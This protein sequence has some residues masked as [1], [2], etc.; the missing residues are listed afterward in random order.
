MGN[1]D[2]K[3][4][5]K[6]RAGQAQG[7]R[8][9]KGSGRRR[10]WIAWLGIAVAAVVIVAGVGVGLFGSSDGGQRG[11][12]SGIAKAKTPQGGETRPILP[13]NRFASAI[14]RRNA[15]KAYE[16]AAAIP[17]ILDKIY[18]YCECEQHSDH[19]S[20]K[21]CF[22]DDHGANCDICIEEALMAKELY[23]QGKTVDQI[24]EAVDREFARYGT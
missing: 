4:M 12:E 19:R 23:D 7:S 22:T 15:D 3:Q 2:R 5:Q 9:A 18:C 16:A 14:Y 6:D 20:L 8:P 10:P 13:A 21:S 11:M 24:K 17:D 1:K